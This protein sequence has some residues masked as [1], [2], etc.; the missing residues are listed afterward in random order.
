M[1]GWLGHGRTR[2]LLAALWSQH[3]HGV[4]KSS[5]R[6]LPLPEGDTVSA[7][8]KNPCV[9]VGNTSRPSAS[10]AASLSHT[11]SPISH[12]AQSTLFG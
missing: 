3:I 10:L 2:E 6:N 7:A 1:K 4:G 9:K 5:S 8:F 12:G 11:V